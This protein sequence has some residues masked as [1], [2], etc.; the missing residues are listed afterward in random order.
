M[1]SFEKGFISTLLTS[2]NFDILLKQN[3]SFY[4][5]TTGGAFALAKTISFM[6]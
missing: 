4:G 1:F 3:I 2:T 5:V 6:K